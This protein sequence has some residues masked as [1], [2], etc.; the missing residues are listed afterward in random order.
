MTSWTPDASEQTGYIALTRR[1]QDIIL[2]PKAQIDHQVL[3]SP[4]PGESL[5]Q[6]DHLISEIR[7]AEGVS[8]RSCEDG[9]FLV[10]W[11]IT[12]EN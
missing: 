12:P 8:I 5:S 6:W 11:F 10:S 1:I 7:D 4:E 2:S 3:I 9:R